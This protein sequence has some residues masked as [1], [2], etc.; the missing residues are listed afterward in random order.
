MSMMQYIRDTIFGGKPN[1]WTEAEWKTFDDNYTAM[2]RGVF[3][4]TDFI[5]PTNL[6]SVGTKMIGL[7][8]KALISGGNRTLF[9]GYVDLFHRKYQEGE[10]TSQ[11]VFMYEHKFNAIGY[12]NEEVQCII[13]ALH[14]CVFPGERKD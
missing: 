8:M 10:R 11:I 12:T 1:S 7:S 9:A 13:L 2:A 14:G 6:A 5:P 3:K 4:W